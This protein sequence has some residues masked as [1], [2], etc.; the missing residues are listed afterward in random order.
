MLKLHLYELYYL[1]SIKDF[2]G[3]FPINNGN[4]DMK[5]ANLGTFVCIIKWMKIKT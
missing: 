3:N 5:A 2:N 1:P 4:M